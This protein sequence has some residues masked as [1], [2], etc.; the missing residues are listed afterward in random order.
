MLKM[1]DPTASHRPRL[2][3][4]AS[5][6]GL[7][8]ASCGL[9][10]L[11][12]RLLGFSHTPTLS[13]APLATPK[14]MVLVTGGRFSMGSDLALS[15]AE[16]P[17]HEV[18]VGSFWLDTHSVTNDQFAKFV[19]ETGYITTAEQIGHGIVP[20][21][22]PGSLQRRTGASWRY[23]DGQLEESEITQGGNYPVVQVSWYDAT[24]Y[25]R[26]AGKRLPT[27][28]EWEFAARA[29]RAA[30]VF[31]WGSVET[32]ANTPQANYRQVAH[33][34][35]D[36][37][38]DGFLGLAPVG[39]F[40]PNRFGLADT[41]GNVWHWCAD[42]YAEDHYA[43]SLGQRPVG[44]PRG[45]HKVVRGGCWLDT[46]SNLKVWARGHQPPDAGYQHVSFRCAKDVPVSP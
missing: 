9:A 4:T 20:G 42:W 33:D 2:R 21:N 31:P 35:F 13:T 18:V 46:A 38:A 32:P 45:K 5:A 7:L 17:A 1:V 39:S 34:E 19:D 10:L 40:P 6:L 3:R 27:E 29:G 37:G 36:S 14:A 44:P 8:I 41:A 25:A 26:W 43:T 23:P 15:A 30:A 28:A 16:R 12:I 22:A 24:A 11:A